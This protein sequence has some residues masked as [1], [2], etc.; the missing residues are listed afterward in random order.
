M[1]FPILSHVKVETKVVMPQFQA[2][3]YHTIEMR[4]AVSGLPCKPVKWQLEL[5]PIVRDVK[6]WTISA[7]GALAARG[8]GALDLSPSSPYLVERPQSLDNA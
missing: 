6:C 4:A 3:L 5:D 7:A 2:V 8:I 1:F